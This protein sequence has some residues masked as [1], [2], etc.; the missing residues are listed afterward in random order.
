MRIDAHLTGSH[1]RLVVEKAQQRRVAEGTAFI[2]ILS[3]GEEE[4]QKG[5]SGCKPGRGQRRGEG[6]IREAYY[7]HLLLDWS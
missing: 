5:E 6:P 3:E 1:N 4:Q 7:T 2:A